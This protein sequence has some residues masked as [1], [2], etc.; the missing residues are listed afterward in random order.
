MQGD[1]TLS[2]KIENRAKKIKNWNDTLNN[3]NDI[4]CMITIDSAIAHLSL[5]LEIPTIVLLKPRFDWRWENLNNQKVF[6]GQKQKF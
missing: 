1:Y 5:A 6:F 3:L 4:D 2:D